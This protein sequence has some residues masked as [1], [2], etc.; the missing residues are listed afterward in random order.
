MKKLILI[1]I[2]IVLMIVSSIAAFDKG[3]GLSMNNEGIISPAREK[4][5][6]AISRGQQ[7]VKTGDYND[8]DL[9]AIFAYLRSVKEEN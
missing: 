2:V 1:P 6:S 4:V 5:D 9:G 8:S 7:L 3:E